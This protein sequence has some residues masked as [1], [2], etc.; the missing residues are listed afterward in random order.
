MSD[1]T[2]ENPQ[3]Q[4][5]VQTLQG[6][7]DLSADTSGGPTSPTAVPATAPAAPA[8]ATASAAPAAVP[9]PGTQAAA[10]QHHGI[11]GEIF[12]TLA[13]GKKKE[14]VVPA[15]GSAPVATY[16]DLKPGEMAR[17]ILAAAITG[18]AGGYDPAN[19]GKG[20]AMASAFA[21]GFKAN[22]QR[23]EKKAGQEEKE[24]QEQ[25]KNQNLSEEMAFRKHKDAIEQQESLLNMAKTQHE[26]NQMI[27]RSDQEKIIF[28][29]QQQEYL[30]KQYAEQDRLKDLHYSFMPDPKDPTKDMSFRTHDEAMAAAKNNPQ[31]LLRPDDFDTRAPF[32]PVSGT[33]KPM[34]AEKGWRDKR[35]MRFAKTDP[36]TGEVLY[37]DKEK[38]KPIPL[39]KLN[40][41][42]ELE[43]P[44]PMTGTEYEAEIRE[45]TDIN[46]KN[47]E[48]A[49]NYATAGE[50]KAKQDQLKEVKEL[51]NALFK[52]GNDPWSV[53]LNTFLPFMSDP[54]KAHFANLAS[55][56]LAKADMDIKGA[57]EEL[58]Q[59]TDP[60][61]IKVLNDSL[62]TSVALANQAKANMSLFTKR[63]NTSEAIANSFYKEHVDTDNVVDEKAALNDF[64]DRVTALKKKNGA[65]MPYSNVELKNARDYLVKK[66]DANKAQIAAQKQEAA[67]AAAN[68]V[69]PDIRPIVDFLANVPPDRRAIQIETAIKNKQLDPD[70]APAVYK[71]FGLTPLVSAKKTTALDVEA[72]VANMLGL[73]GSAADIAAQQKQQE[74][75]EQPRK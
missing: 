58:Q 44:R 10:D 43:I 75:Q 65:A 15:D 45:T 68:P 13:G 27:T 32:D 23:V 34:I 69:D 74:Q 41:E 25:F 11:L 73:K 19:R 8:P 51:N 38:T 6:P 12:Q 50:L 70:K 16:R 36:K 52:S 22:E 47:S 5:V 26:I 17:G 46:F 40:T 33:W 29:Q 53:D 59:T 60:A 2:P 66:I 3:V 37:Y 49:K 18:L 56:V 55:G 54:Q 61:R 57:R 71:H 20:P 30:Q 63:V 72:D 39:G 62:T 14:W 21:G 9:T 64:D 24:A 31:V 67:T 42:G 48:T 7:Q 28:T 35:E 1:Q 4:P